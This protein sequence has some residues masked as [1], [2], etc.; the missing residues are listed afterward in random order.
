MP[1]S[2]RDKVARCD[3]CR[4]EPVGGEFPRAVCPRCD[5]LALTDSASPARADADAGCGDNPVYINGR[6]CWRCYFRG[7]W[8]TMTDVDNCR[9]LDEF[10]RRNQLPPPGTD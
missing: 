4:R 6:L 7:G 9:D 8:V 10:C 3:I 5:A 2:R 1:T